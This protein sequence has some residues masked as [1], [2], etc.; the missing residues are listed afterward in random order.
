VISTPP[1]T[2][3]D[4]FIR[5]TGFDGVRNMEQSSCAIAAVRE[6]VKEHYPNLYLIGTPF[7]GIGIP[8]G[9]KQAK[10]LVQLLT[11]SSTT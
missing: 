2:Y 3:K 5:D 10:E 9:V 8:D 11:K 7:D 4:W 1:A 6:H